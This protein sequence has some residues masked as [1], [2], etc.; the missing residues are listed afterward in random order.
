MRGV[1]QLMG[2]FC[3]KLKLGSTAALDCRTGQNKGSYRKKELSFLFVSLA[4]ILDK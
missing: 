4:G 1:Y 3:D 2:L